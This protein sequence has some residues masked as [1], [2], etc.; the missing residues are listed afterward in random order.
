MTNVIGLI[1]VPFFHYF[2]KLERF[3]CIL[4]TSKVAAYPS[5]PPLGTPFH[6]C[7]EYA[8]T[9]LSEPNTL[10]YLISPTV[11]KRKVLNH[12]QQ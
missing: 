4:S 9:V 8:G 7:K 2:N 10:A 12:C 11:T 3:F 1:S 5:K 6:I